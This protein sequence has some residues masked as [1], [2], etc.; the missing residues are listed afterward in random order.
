MNWYKF[1]KIASAYGAWLSPSGEEIVVENMGHEKKA[2]EILKE[3]H[4][5]EEMPGSAWTEMFKLGYVRL[6]YQ[7]FGVT[8]SNHSQVTNLQKKVIAQMIRE[9]GSMR[10]DFFNMSTDQSETCR[11]YLCAIDLVRKL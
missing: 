6:N 10:F 8:V 5:Y 3:K 2:F 9:S 1:Y 11:D 4:G 7:P